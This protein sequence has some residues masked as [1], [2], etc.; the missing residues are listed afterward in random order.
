MPYLPTGWTRDALQ[1]E[2][3]PLN[4]AGRLTQLVADLDRATWPEARAGFFRV[5]KA[6][7]GILGELAITGL[8]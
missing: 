7:P 2:L 5:K 3:G 6:I 8:G 1:G 4:E